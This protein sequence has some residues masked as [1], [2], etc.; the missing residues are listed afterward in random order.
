MQKFEDFYRL[1]QEKPGIH[2]YQDLI[3]TISSK[4]GTTLFILYEDLLAF[5]PLIAEKL[6]KDPES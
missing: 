6:K 2:K 1:F 3:N 4:G 5:D